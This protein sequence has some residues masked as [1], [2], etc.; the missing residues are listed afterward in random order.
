M[1]PPSTPAPAAGGRCTEDGGRLRERPGSAGPAPHGACPG[2]SQRRPDRSLTV[3]L[4]RRWHAEDGKDTVAHQL[5][6]ATPE[7]LDVLARTLVVGRQ[8]LA[9]VLGVRSLGVR[10][11]A[12]QIGEQHRDETALFGGDGRRDDRSGSADDR[13]TTRRAEPRTGRQLGGAGR[14]GEQERAPALETES[15]PIRGIDTTRGTSQAHTESLGT[16]LG[17]GHRNGLSAGDHP[18]EKSRRWNRR[19]FFS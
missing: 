9:H 8:A 1:P 18:N 19:L 16:G 5:L 12:H 4:V 11:E 7:A 15:G 14:A 17:A 2:V 10:R 3:V 13:L 6:Y